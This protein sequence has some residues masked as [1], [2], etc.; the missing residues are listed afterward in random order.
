MPPIRRDLARPQPTMPYR[1]L[2]SNER[3]RR[4][5]DQLV[6]T[7]RDVCVRCWDHIACD[8][9][10][11]VGSRYLPLKGSQKWVE[12]EGERL[13]QWQYEIDRGAR[14]KVA[15]GPDFVVVV[16]VSSGHPK[17]NE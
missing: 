14:V 17:E 10:T 6:R 7:R 13:P 16:S 5:W 8:P 15:I 2:V 11:P 3:V 1:V 9:T 12:F 4:D